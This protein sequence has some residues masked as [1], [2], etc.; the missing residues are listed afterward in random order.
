LSSC[1]VAVVRD[2]QEPDDIGWKRK[3]REERTRKRKFFSKNVKDEKSS[4]EDF[5]KGGKGPKK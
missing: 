4:K 3:D 5:E 2:W 1:Y